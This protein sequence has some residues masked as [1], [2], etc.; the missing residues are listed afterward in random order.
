M[1]LTAA[2]VAVVGGV[3]CVGAREA[4]LALAGLAVALLVSPFIADPQPEPIALAARV[5]AAVL[6]A[7]LPWIVVRDPAASTRG[8]LLG[9]AV[10]ALVAAAA[11]VVGFGA[12]GLGAAA[13]GPAEAQGAGFALVALSVAPLAFGRDVFRLGSGAVLLVVGALLIR[14]G[15]AGTPASLEELV[16]AVLL[17]G[18][19]GAIAF[20][21]A[22]AV[23]S[24]AEDGL[25]LAPD[26]AVEDDGEAS[27]STTQAVDP[28]LA[29]G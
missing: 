7:Y 14:V 24:G 25:A 9:W 12:A 17:V 21:A 6:A 16:S 29:R 5:V 28:H 3:A 1:L 11:F 27:P 13:V 26:L 10:D 4:R 18:M 2:V 15:L 22:G 23:V 19:C 8:S 20:L